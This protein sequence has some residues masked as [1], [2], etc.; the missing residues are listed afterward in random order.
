MQRLYPAIVWKDPSARSYGLTFPDLPG[1]TTS[2]DDIDALYEAAQEAGALW[3]D[4][5]HESA[6]APPEATALEAVPISPS[7]HKDGAI[8]V[9]LVPVV[10]PS[11]AIRIGEIDRAAAQRGTTRSGFLAEAARNLMRRAS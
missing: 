4:A 7:E 3:I 11:R 2:A 1:C 5:E 10:L 6:R 8:G 9:I